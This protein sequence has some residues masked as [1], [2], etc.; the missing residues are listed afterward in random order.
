[1]SE[2]MK[3]NV[4]FDQILHF[5][6]YTRVQKNWQKCDFVLA[7][8][9]PTPLPVGWDTKSGKNILFNVKVIE[10]IYERKTVPKRHRS[11]CPK[12]LQYIFS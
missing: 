6:E 10:A 12:N 3:D 5:S 2:Q 7:G 4:V 11:M 9:S 8:G 1:M